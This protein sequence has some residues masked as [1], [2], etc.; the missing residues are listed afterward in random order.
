MFYFTGSADEALTEWLR[1]KD[2][3]LAGRQ[4]RPKVDGI[5]IADLCTQFLAAK[6][7]KLD[8]GELSPL[9]FRTYRSTAE[10]LTAAYGRNRVASDI[11]VGEWQTLRASIAKTHG[12][13]AIGNEIQRIRSKTPSEKQLNLDIFWLKDDSHQDSDSLPDPDILADEIAEDLESALA[14]FK[15]VAKNIRK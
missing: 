15:T 3:L 14:L 11:S 2:D 4:A 9:T 7:N 6:E 5:T 1:V 10:R 8:A 13:I 12:P